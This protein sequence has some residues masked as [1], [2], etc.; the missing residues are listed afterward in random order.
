MRIK[1][2]YGTTDISDYLLS[3]ESTIEFEK[4]KLIG[5]TPS[6]KV[7]IEIDNYN[8]VINDYSQPIYV[9]DED[10]KIGTYHIC[11][12]PET[13][14]K[15]MKI[16]IYD[17]MMSLNKPYL[18]KMTY[19]CT[20]ND[21]IVEMEKLAGVKINYH[22]LPSSLLNKEINWYDN[23]INMRLFIGWIA[24]C[25]GMNVFVDA[26]GIINFQSLSRQQ[27]NEIS[28]NDIE[29]YTLCN[30]VMISRVEFNNGLK[31][32]ERGEA[33]KDTLYISSDNPYIEDQAEIERIYDMYQGLS[34]KSATSIKIIEIPELKPGNI[35]QYDI[36]HWM[37][38]SIKTVYHGGEY[39][40]QEI[41]GE[42][43]SKEYQV[44]S[45]QIGESAKIRML[46]IE[47]NRNSNEVKIVAKE[48][49]G[50]NKAYA[51]LVLD[52]N[53]IKQ[54]VKKTGELLYLMETGSG[55]IFDN[56]DQYV[57]K[58]S[59][60]TEVK[61]IAD[62]PLGINMQELRN[63]DICMAVD[64]KTVKAIARSLNSRIGCRF[65]ITYQDNT[66]DTFEVWVFIGVY[67]LKVIRGNYLVDYDRR[68]WKAFH[69]KDKEIKYV[70]N[71]G[72]Y[73]EVNG[74]YVSI[75]HPKVEFGTK[76]TG[77]QY[78]LTEIRD[79][80]TIIQ[81]EYSEIKQEVGSISLSVV[82]VTNE[83]TTVK[84]KQTEQEKRLQSAEIKLT[85][86]NII[87]AV[88]EKLSVDGKIV[89][90]STTLDKDGFHV[91][92]KGIDLTNNANK[93]VFTLDENGNVVMNDATA[94]N[95][96]ANNAKLSGE[97]TNIVGNKTMKLSEVELSFY[98]RDSQQREIKTVTINNERIDINAASGLP[99]ASIY[100][101]NNLMCL[102]NG[103]GLIGIV[104]EMFLGNSTTAPSI[105]SD[106]SNV[107]ITGR[108]S[109]G[110]LKVY[111]EKTLDF[112]VNH[113]F[114]ILNG[115]M[116]ITEN[117]TVGGSLTVKNT[118]YKNKVMTTATGSV[119]MESLET[120]T[121]MFEDTG[122]GCTDK[123]GKIRIY[124][125]EI[126]MQVTNTKHE[127]FVLIQ[128]CG[129]G[130]LW[131]SERREDYF[132]VEGTPNL[133]FMWCVKARQQGF[134][135][136]RYRKV[137]MKEFTPLSEQIHESVYQPIADLQK[138]RNKAYENKYDEILKERTRYL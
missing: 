91:K 14:D 76:P 109:V 61:Y 6:V 20:V 116:Q 34:F 102:G 2:L 16:T 86:T 8:K 92:G 106:G 15:K 95:I 43:S 60:D 62:M 28:L 124:F 123:N 42:F 4:N 68:V 63:K 25:A 12:A 50:L 9:Y 41:N 117:L 52:T 131:V 89:T 22:T 23:T 104:G 114:C 33:T 39:A 130:K 44:L 1:I 88:N 32:L 133:S 138:E 101:Y 110:G 10:T 55:N 65:T 71:L 53:A 135:V 125:D 47:V 57:Q 111:N 137:D 82:D 67:T 119:A 75:G 26:N 64:I 107:K 121:P 115:F 48:Q 128:E 38:M 66:T 31:L 97:F 18:T 83:I 56:C 113:G 87:Q 129:T 99:V 79:N 81:N 122:T 54:D 46:T 132:V 94:N 134:E 85:P 58:D 21:Q 103:V 5:N 59:S 3:F 27:T 73:A 84:G 24:E 35:I 98:Q 93:K 36:Y 80:I 72:I 13:T 108:G 40:I 90:S 7:D 126:W 105:A 78:D 77:F 49:D 17:S 45:R 11:D 74:E 70:S 29:T 30:D 69:V 127:Y 51:Q 100:G 118:G 37:P 136:E 19:P 112:S 120:P 96:I